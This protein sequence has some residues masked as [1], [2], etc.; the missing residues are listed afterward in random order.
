MRVTKICNFYF[1]DFPYSEESIKRILTVSNN[2]EE[3]IFSNNKHSTMDDA[4]CKKCRENRNS[5]LTN[6]T[7]GKLII[8]F[9]LN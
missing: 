7:E 4:V 1:K 9:N 3:S 5:L 6:R 2:G 8:K